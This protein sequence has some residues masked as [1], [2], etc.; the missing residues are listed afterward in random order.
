MRDVV[1]LKSR[2]I[3]IAGVLVASVKF[4]HADVPQLPKVAADWRVGDREWHRQAAG[5]AAAVLCASAAGSRFVSVFPKYAGS[6]EKSPRNTG[7][8]Y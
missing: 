1:T 8:L 4:N 2:G 6:I 5:C 3:H 7:T